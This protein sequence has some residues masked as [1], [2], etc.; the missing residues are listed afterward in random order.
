MKEWEYTFD[1][2]SREDW[3]KQIETDL[4]QKPLSSLQNEWWPG[5]PLLPLLHPDELEGEPIKLPDH[6]FNQPPRITEFIVTNGTPAPKVNHEIL[7]ALQY[8]AQSI[9]LHAAISES[10]NVDVWFKS[11]M[12]EIISLSI[13]PDNINLDNIKQI[14]KASQGDLIYRLKRNAQSLPIN[15]ILDAFLSN[16][17]VADSLRFIYNFPSSGNWIEETSEIL[18]RLLKD[19]EEW[20]SYGFKHEA[21]FDQ[22]ILSVEADP[23]YFKHIIQTRVLHLLCQNIKDHDGLEPKARDENY[24]ECHILQHKHE[25]P[26]RF[27]IRA[28]MSALAA[29]LSGTHALCIHHAEHMDTQTYY[30]RINRNIHHLLNLESGMYKGIDPLAGSVALDFHARAWTKKIWDLLSL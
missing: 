26:E 21:F 30:K 22:C 28:S 18:N 29:A 7:E 11:V 4:R 16:H 24:L 20:S 9:I 17:N 27:L 3:I 5:E 25:N 2:V 19:L 12:K 6:F 23:S 13:Q 8:G 15:I 14:S 1:P 10:L